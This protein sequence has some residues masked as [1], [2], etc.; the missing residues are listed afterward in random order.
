[1]TRVYTENE[2]KE[3]DK[4]IWHPRHI[5]QVL[6]HIRN[7]NYATVH[8]YL[9]DKGIEIQFGNNEDTPIYAKSE[10]YVSLCEMAENLIACITDSTIENVHGSI[11][12]NCEFEHYEHSS[13]PFGDCI[14]SSAQLAATSMLK[15]VDSNL[16]LGFAVKRFDVTKIVAD[17]D[18][19]SS[20]QT[21]KDKVC[22]VRC[23]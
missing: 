23:S 19:E 11:E 14:V 4:A 7:N 21:V 2:I 12:L 9:D 20:A 16:S 10:E 6:Q 22:G 3:L 18:A 8:M 17:L 15:L 13:D 5:K 1:M